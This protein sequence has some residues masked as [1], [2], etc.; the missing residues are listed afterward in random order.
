[1]LETMQATPGLRRIEAQLMAFFPSELSDA[2]RLMGFRAYRR[3]FMYL[4]LKSVASPN[5]GGATRRLP[6]RLEPWGTASLDAAATLINRAYQNHIDSEV[7]DQYCTFAGSLRFLNNVIQYPGCG[8]FDE[9][10]SA[11]ARNNSTDRLEGMILASRVKEDVAH[12]TQICVSPERQSKGIGRALLARTVDALRRRK[13]EGVTLTVTQANAGA[14]ALYEKFG[15]I[16][17]RDFD[18][19]VWERQQ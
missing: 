12:I 3:L 5:G 8:T 2:F 11:L 7:N 4:R 17:L 14:V 15:F 18:A 1:M 19:Y 10:A 6:V 9:A 16:T 13:F